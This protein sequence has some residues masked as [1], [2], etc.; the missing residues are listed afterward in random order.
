MFSEQGHSSNIRTFRLS[1]Y[2]FHSLLN[3][4]PC[5]GKSKLDCKSLKGQVE[6]AFSPSRI[7]MIIARII[8]EEPKGG[9]LDSQGI[10]LWR[11]LH[12]LGQRWKVSEGSFRR[13]RIA[14]LFITVLQKSYSR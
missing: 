5:L 10:D 9:S 2:W 13:I 11:G 14:V 6:R 8:G 7:K 4:E 3:C 12:L 1:K